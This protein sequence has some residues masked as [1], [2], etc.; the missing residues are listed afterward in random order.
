M[1]PNTRK[2]SLFAVMLLIGSTGIAEAQAPIGTRAAGLAGA[3]V[4][5]AD[6]A[7]AVYW[8]PAGLATGPIVSFLASFGDD[9][10]AQD[11]TQA[12]AGEQHTGRI[13]A[14]SLPPI[15]IAYYRSG[16][17]GTQRVATAVTGPPSREEVRRSVQALTTSTVGVSLLQ[18]LT[19][20]IVVGA[21]PKVVWGTAARG[22]T[23]GLSA[24]DALD[25]A[26]DLDG[27]SRSTFDVDAAVM[28]ALQRLRLGLVAR[29]LTAPAFEVSEGEEIELSREVRVGAA[30][31]SGWPGHSRVVVSVDG[32]VTSRVTPFGDRR[33]LAA[34]VETWWGNRRVG[35]R[36]GVRRSTVGEARAA[37]AAGVSYAVRPSMFVESHVTAGELNERGWSIGARMGF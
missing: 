36:G 35:L 11:D 19:E 3:F 15:G 7:S 25:A 10:T 27:E 8:N 5:V 29:N 23:T 22:Q 30:W 18:S 21:T 20:Y 9:K 6:D 33:D 31:G 4:G 17:F 2:S 24:G 26:A 1:I 12:V 16:V 28:V 14:L 13:V 37:V 34:G 32:D